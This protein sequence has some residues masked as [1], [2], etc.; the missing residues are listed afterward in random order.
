MLGR[1]EEVVVSQVEGAFRLTLDGYFMEFS[2]PARNKKKRCCEKKL[3]FVATDQALLA[4]YGTALARA[5]VPIKVAQTLLRH[6]DPKLTMNVYAHLSA[7]DLH[8]AIADA[9]P[10]LTTEA[11]VERV[12]KT[13]TDSSPVSISNT[14]QNAPK[15]IVD[16][17][18]SFIS[19]PFTS[20]GQ[21]TLNQRVEGSSPSGGILLHKDLRRCKNLPERFWQR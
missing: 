15:G 18:N 10:D 16:G 7:F 17:C 19:Q 1:L 20:K 13:G 12:V 4:G 9:L 11:P 21:L 6:S 8:G 3:C 5:G 14:P 2:G